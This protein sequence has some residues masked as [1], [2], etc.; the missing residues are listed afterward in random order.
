MDAS[1]RNDW[2]STIVDPFFYPSISGSW[3][4]IEMF[5]VLK[6]FVLEFLKLRGGWAKI[7]AATGA[8]QT[9]RYYSSA[10]YNIHGAGQFYNPT[11]YPPVGLRPESVVTAEVSL[12]AR[13]FDN[14]LGFDVALY[15]KNTT[16]QI[17]SADVSR[18][19]GYSSMKINAGEIN[20]K[21]IE[22]QLTATPVRTG[23]FQ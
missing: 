17:L 22:V 9:D 8:Y 6:G 14:R 4:I 11:T 1:A 21:G 3:I 15:N 20:N 23:D 13:F 10:G 16:D 7:G 18:S 5:P 19:T 12:E 2:S